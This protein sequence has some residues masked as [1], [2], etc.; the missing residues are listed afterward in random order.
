VLT[1]Q[2]VY[3]HIKDQH[4]P[5]Y[6]AEKLVQ[7]LA[8]RDYWQQLWVAYGDEIFDDLRSP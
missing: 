5:W 8:W 6:Q 3:A 4:I 7:E 1:T 2:Q